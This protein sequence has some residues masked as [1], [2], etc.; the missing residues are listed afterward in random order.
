MASDEYRKQWHKYLPLAFLNYDTSHRRSLG[1][2]LT[3]VFHCRLPYTF[4]V[5]GL[6]L[7]FDP[8]LKVTRVFPDERLKRTQVLYDDTQEECHAVLCQI[9]KII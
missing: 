1:C 9:P 2:K 3:R 5:H 4:L 6:G 7:E 8:N